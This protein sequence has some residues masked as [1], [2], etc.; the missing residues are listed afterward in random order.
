[1]LRTG[2][3]RDCEGALCTLDAVKV[4]PFHRSILLL[5]HMSHAI[6]RPSCGKKGGGHK[7]V[8]GNKNLRCV[9]QLK[10]ARKQNIVQDLIMT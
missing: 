10:L 1:M 7:N 9:F 6:N 3:G 8:R 4:V 5:F 2:R